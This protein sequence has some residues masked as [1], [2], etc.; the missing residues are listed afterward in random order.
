MA[1]ADTKS[2]A[3]VPDDKQ[4]AAGVEDGSMDAEKQKAKR[5]RP[6]PRKAD[7]EE[8]QYPGYLKEG[9]SL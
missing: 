6:D 1:I 9:G 8:V 2:P 4:P 5:K 7:P 3:S